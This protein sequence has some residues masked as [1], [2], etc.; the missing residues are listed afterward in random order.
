MDVG[1]SR[2]S[3]RS[4]PSRRFGWV[5]YINDPERGFGTGCFFIFVTVVT[6][7]SRRVHVRGKSSGMGATGG[8]RSVY[9]ILY[10]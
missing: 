5:Q 2:I 7:G 10:P 1:Q 4:S 8:I 9:G 3:G 6:R